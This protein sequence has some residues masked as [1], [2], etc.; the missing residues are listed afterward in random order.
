MALLLP[1]AGHRSRALLPC[2][3]SN[4]AEIG[5]GVCRTAAIRAASLDGVF[6]LKQAKDYQLK[7]SEPELTRL[8]NRVLTDYRNALGDHERR[9][10]KWAEYMRRW[11]GTP[12]APLLGEEAKSNY[13]VPLIRWNVFA[14]WAKEMDSLFGD[15]AEIIAVP[16]GPSDYRR[17]KKIGLYMTWRVFDSMKLTNPFCVFVLRKL[18][19][20]RAFAYAPYTRDTYDVGGKEVIDYEGPEFTPLHPDDLITPVEEVNTLHEFS[21]VTRRYRVTPDQLLQGEEEGKYQGI[22]A[23]FES[24]LNASRSRQ[25]REFQGEEIKLEQDLAEGLDYR[26]PLSSGNSLVVLE[27]YGKW[28]KLKGKDASE[29]SIKGRELRESDW[30]VRFLLDTNKVI[31]VQDLAELYPMKKNKRPF[32][33][34]SMV[35]DGSYWSPGLA[36]MLVDSEDEIRVNHNLGTQ[37]QQFSVGTMIFFRPDY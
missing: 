7:L 9:I 6:Q 14:Q 1:A 30:V 32:V 24:I 2:R 31:G 4:P 18:L 12:D 23:N 16:V 5:A 25:R 28:R 29:D 26:V 20:G 21:H 22:T 34:A 36:E 10:A 33:E 13:P 15:D 35:K 19:F 27:W 8:G 3:V 11:R 17:V 37:A